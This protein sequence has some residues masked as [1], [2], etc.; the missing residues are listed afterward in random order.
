MKVRRWYLAFLP[1]LISTLVLVGCAKRP[2]MVQASAPAPAGS[3]AAGVSTSEEAPQSGAAST[4]SEGAGQSGATEQS[5]PTTTAGATQPAAAP[6][7]AAPSPT[8][9]S[10]NAGATAGA[11][12][13]GATT[14]GAGQPAA[15][16]KEESGSGAATGGG[17]TVMGPAGPAGLAGPESGAGTPAGASS[18]DGASESATNGGATTAGSETVA[19]AQPGD[20]MIAAARPTLREYAAVPELQDV[21]FGFDKYSIRT[22]D[23]KVLEANAQWL[24]SNPTYLVLIEGH[25]DERGTNEYNIALGQHRAKSVMDYL[26]SQG[27]LASR[28]TTISYGEER[29]LCTEH[30]EDCW[31]KNRRAHFLVKAQ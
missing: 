23:V 9:V 6:P 1:L 5:G 8:V 26:V 17:T 20:Q 10:W 4:G 14:S 30:T 13:S 27:V 12:A 18:T 25:C 31:G 21:H 16:S 7:V 24:K 2:S 28:I 29:P 19:V 22:E 15:G 11:T 3:A